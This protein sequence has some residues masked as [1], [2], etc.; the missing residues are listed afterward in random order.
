VGARDHVLGPSDARVTVVEYGDYECP[1]CRQVAPIIEQLRSRFGDRLRYVFRHFPI[2]T[3]HP[4]AQLAAE[5]AEAAGAQGKFWEMHDLLL[6]PQA[7]LDKPSL[8][9]YAAE[10]ALDTERFERE[11]SEHV[12]ADRVRQDFLSGVRSGANGTPAFFLNGIRYDGPWDLDSLIAEIQKPLGVQ[13]RLLFQQFTRLQASS[14]I[15]LLLATALALFWANS[16]WSHGYF[17][18]WETHLSI[19]LGGFSLDESLLHWVN[20]GL[21][22]IFFFV[23]GLEIKREILVGELA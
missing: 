12:Y 9:K 2:T 19:T 18:L 17:E 13:V 3:M 14:G 11:L 15:L 5:A 16:A 8:V 23:V 1:H 21:M 10:L 4:R 7:S 20:D 22:V 6:E